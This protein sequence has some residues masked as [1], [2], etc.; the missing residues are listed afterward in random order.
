MPQLKDILYPISIISGTIIG[1]GIF[2][3]PYITSKVGFGTIIFYFLVLGAL[4]TL[5]HLFF[6][7]LAVKTPDYK[8]LPG[9][10]RIYL[11]KWG[12]K[13]A[14]FSIILGLFGAILAY[15]IVGGEFL[16]ELFSPLMFKATA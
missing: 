14:L 13:V 2:S 5:I 9:F 11:G 12:E 7:Q 6:G 4:V 15:L 10:A 3:L 8:R 16:S 1:A